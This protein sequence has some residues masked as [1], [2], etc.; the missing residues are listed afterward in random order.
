MTFRAHPDP[1]QSLIPAY[2]CSLKLPDVLG[3]A[4][5]T[6]LDQNLFRFRS[7][8][9]EQI[10]KVA[11]RLKHENSGLSQ[12]LDQAEDWLCRLRAM[13]E[14]PQNSLPDIVIWMLQGDKRVAF[15]R[16][17]AHQVLY[18]RNI[19]NCCGR[20]CGKLQTIFLKVPLEERPG[21]ILI[22]QTVF[23]H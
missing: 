22:F 4:S 20:N 11:L 14:E 15:A 19:P 18:S 7:T 17:P 13:A 10:L 6:H 9:L 8:H 21:G 2:P 23:P 12:I 16:V 5:S 3:K 1:T